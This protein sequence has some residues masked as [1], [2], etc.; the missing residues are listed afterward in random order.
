MNG[1]LLMKFGR[2]LMKKVIW[3]SSPNPNQSNPYQNFIVVNIGQGYF[4]KTP[5]GS[6]H[7]D[8]VWKKA[9]FKVFLSVQV[10]YL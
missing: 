3:Q 5:K 8:L 4:D 6:R 10:S 2:L 7:R 9:T 1:W